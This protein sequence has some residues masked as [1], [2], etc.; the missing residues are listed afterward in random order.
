MVI[1]GGVAQGLLNMTADIYFQ[2]NVQDKTTGIIKRSWRYDKTIICHID[3][4]TTEGASTPDNNKNFDREYTQEER[5]RMKTK[6]RL[7]KR[8]RVSNIKNRSGEILFQEFEQIDSPPTIFEIES[9]HPRLDPLG[10]VLYFETN[11][12]RVSVQSNDN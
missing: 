9:H 6:E 1:Y 10:N 4:I 12:R 3:I 7:S 11:L 2:E 8:M 5:V